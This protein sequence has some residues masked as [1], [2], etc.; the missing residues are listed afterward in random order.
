MQFDFLGQVDSSFLQ[1]C[2][3]LTTKHVVGIRLCKVLEFSVA[4]TAPAAD[5]QRTLTLNC[6]SAICPPEGYFLDDQKGQTLS[7]V[8]CLL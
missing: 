1:V 6:D 2:C 4:V 3:R 8:G 5:W 7:L